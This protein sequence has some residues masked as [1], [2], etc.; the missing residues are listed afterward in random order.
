[1]VAF[2]NYGTM[3]IPFWKRIFR[4]ELKEVT[5]LDCH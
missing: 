3:K 1:M 4:Q 2:P 5:P